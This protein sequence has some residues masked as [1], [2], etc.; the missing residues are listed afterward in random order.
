MLFRQ[1]LARK[2]VLKII[3]PFIFIAF[4]SQ[5]LI[6]ASASKEHSKGINIAKTSLETVKTSKST[7]K[8]HELSGNESRSIPKFWWLAP[9]GAVCALIYVRKFYKEVMEYPEGDKKMVDIASHVR[10][11]AY[12][13]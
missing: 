9:I 1:S 13:Y 8:S 2:L 7:K 6:Y 4:V 11:G 3:L 5:G 12:A 10:E